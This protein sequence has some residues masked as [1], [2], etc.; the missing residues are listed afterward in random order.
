[1]QPREVGLSRFILL[2]IIFLAGLLLVVGLKA[3]FSH[4]N[5]QLNAQSVNERARL[6]IGEEIV[7]NIQAMEKDVYEMTTLAG[8]AAQARQERIFLARTAE[9]EH[10]LM[11]LRN[12]GVVKRVIDLNIEGHDRMVHE[13]RYQPEP[14][15]GRY[16]LELIEVGPLLG[17]IKEKVRELR[18]ILAERAIQREAG[19]LAGIVEVEH[20][21]SLFL[22]HL[23]PYF[24]RLSE[25]ANRLYFESNER[26]RILEGEIEKQRSRYQL[27]E[28]LLITLVVLLATLLSILFAKQIRDSNHRLRIAW[29]EMHAAKEAAEQASR[30]K[31][32][33][34]SRMSHEL[35]TPMNAILGFAQ[36]LEE[37]DLRPEQ[38][39]FVKEINRAGG[40]L[41]D[42]IN[43][44]LD[45]AK[46]EAGG[47]TLERIGFAPAQLAEQV[48]TLVRTQASERGLTFRL[49][50]AEDVP[51]YI[52]GDPT[53]LRQ[54]LINLIGNALKFTREGGIN[55]RVGPVDGGRRIE[56]SVLDSGI[57]MDAETVRGLFK[58]FS[59]ADESVTR[60]FGGTG[61][62]LAISRDLVRA[63]GGDIHVESTPGHG[64]RFWFQLPVEQADAAHDDVWPVA[65]APATGHDT[66]SAGENHQAD[67]LHGHVLL[68]EDNVVNQVIA[69]RMLTKLGLTH[70]LA[71]NGVEALKKLQ[72]AASYDVALMD[73]QM[74][75]MDGMEATR[76]LRAWEAR[77]LRQ[78]LP[79]IAMTANAL[80]EDRDACIAS[81]MD[82]HLGKPVKLE[83]LAA[84]LRRWLPG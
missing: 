5:D 22:K 7:R 39:D 59:Q 69:S 11:V 77:E 44:V 60:K 83:T 23:P 29:E 47:M 57:G 67:A 71:T 51:Q 62:G 35:R 19:N 64:S 37:D 46:I 55:F 34:V 1:M 54:V 70:D 82:D 20:R 79:V 74:P 17:P 8:E 2:I 10:D 9:L 30:A 65:A 80:S 25:N 68:V 78:R 56:F 38:Q 58:P 26:L 52:L 41:L 75:Q 12:G 43:Q 72:G 45:L 18:G 32:A 3:F 49:E 13:K 42:L 6:F 50:L 24:Q 61:L 21:V 84:V 48:A 31:S 66:A 36:L 40:H 63:M 27:I 81:G 4:L 33:F 76:T 15:D 28:N 16:L 53:R 14:T 73:V